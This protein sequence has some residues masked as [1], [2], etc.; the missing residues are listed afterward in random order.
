M[1]SKAKKKFKMS[2]FIKK[3]EDDQYKKKKKEQKEQQK[4]LKIRMRKE[5]KERKKKMRAMRARVD[6]MEKEELMR[7][8]DKEKEDGTLREKYMNRQE[9]EV[10]MLNLSIL[11]GKLSDEQLVEEKR[12]PLGMILWS[13]DRKQIERGR[14]GT[15]Q[16][17][18][19]EKIITGNK[20]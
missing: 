4:M 16:K 6:E 17:E 3:E 18:E 2:R 12:T 11:A 15:K 9:H 10:V 14:T 13:W 7:W 8:K 1:D 20:I 5:R 19:V